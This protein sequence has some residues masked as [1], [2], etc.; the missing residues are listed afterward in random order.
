MKA[1]DVRRTVAIHAGKKLL[2]KAAKKF[3]TAKLHVADV[4]VPREEITKNI[5]RSYSQIY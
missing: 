2:E 1:V 5:E 3:T 4:T